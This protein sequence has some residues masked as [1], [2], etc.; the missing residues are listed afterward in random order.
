MDETPWARGSST[1]GQGIFHLGQGD[2]PI[3]IHMCDI[4]AFLLASAM[5]WQGR[6]PNENTST[7]GSEGSFPFLDASLMV[8]KCHAPSC[9]SL[10]FSGQPLKP[11]ISPN[12]LVKQFYKQLD[13]RSRFAASYC[14][15]PS[16][17]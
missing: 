7:R 11:S 17:G 15:S 16:L 5:M 10:F 9:A 14:F 8:T 6:D 3:K 2:L 12:K 13:R 4:C 1:L